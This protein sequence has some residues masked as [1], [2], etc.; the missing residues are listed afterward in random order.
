[1]WSSLVFLISRPPCPREESRDFSCFLTEREVVWGGR[2][3]P[4]VRPFTWEDLGLHDTWD[5]LM[6]LKSIYCLSEWSS[7]VTGRPASYLAILLQRGRHWKGVWLGRVWKIVTHLSGK[8]FVECLESRG[9][10]IEKRRQKFRPYRKPSP[11]DDR[12]R[13]GPSLRKRPQGRK[14]H[15]WSQPHASLEPVVQSGSTEAQ[16]LCTVQRI[17][18]PRRLSGFAHSCQSWQMEIWGRREERKRNSII[19]TVWMP[20]CIRIYYIHECLPDYLAHSWWVTN[21][22]YYDLMV[23]QDRILVTLPQLPFTSNHSRF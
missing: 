4:L 20:L 6:I 23:I 5:T 16:G 17:P 21:G 9:Q 8:V 2:W 10:V 11:T 19:F 14:R 7:I 22:R 18:E 3:A 15:L 1:M 13:A 12:Q